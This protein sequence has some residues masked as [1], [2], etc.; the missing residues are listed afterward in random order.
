[1]HNVPGKSIYKSIFLSGALQGTR[2]A[3]DVDGAVGRTNWLAAYMYCSEGELENSK[4]EL[5]KYTNSNWK[6]DWFHEYVD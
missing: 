1:M 4:K 5:I 6:H 2:S 3:G